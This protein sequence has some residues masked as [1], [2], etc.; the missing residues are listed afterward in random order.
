MATADKNITMNISAFTIIKV[1]FVGLVFVALWYI[2]DLV[3]VV[4]TAIVIASFVDLITKKIP[5]D[6]INRT[7]SVILIYFIGGGLVFALFY[8]FIPVFINEI[9]ELSSVFSKY[10][11][12]A[13]LISNTQNQTIGGVKELTSDVARNVSLEEIIDAS[14]GI[15]SNLSTGVLQVISIAFGGFLNFIL[16]IVL[17]FYFSIREKGI[18]GFLRIIVPTKYEDYGINL[19]QRTEKRIGLWVQGQFILSLLVGVLVYL[20]LAILGVKYALILAIFTAVFEIVP[21][22]LVL[23]I[24]PALIFGYMDGGISMLLWVGGLYIIVQQFENYLLQPLV[25]KKVVG[26]SPLVVILSILIG[27]KLA[28]VWGILLA[29]PVS[30][31]ILEFIDDLER[32]KVIAKEAKKK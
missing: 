13:E 32:H 21:M 1:F 12:S 14:R 2:R 24:I 8:F 19:W 16:I 23:A 4:I 18:E 31:V 11:P 15:I 3:L 20:G 30:V 10:I 29:V 22:G 9:S 27:A 5:A 26:I 28:G 6:K 17:S 7:V 25:I